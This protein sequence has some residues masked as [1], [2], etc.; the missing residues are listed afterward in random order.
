MIVLMNLTT[1]RYFNW[2]FDRP[3]REYSKPL[4]ACLVTAG[5]SSTR[6]RSTDLDCRRGSACAQ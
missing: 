3:C 5:P 6:S 2:T 4:V 1:D